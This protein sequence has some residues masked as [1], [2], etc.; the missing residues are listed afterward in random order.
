MPFSRN[1]ST[2]KGMD[3]KPSF[4]PVVGIR[5]RQAN[6][7]LFWRA[8]WV[9]LRKAGLTLPQSNGIGDR[10]SEQ[11]NTYQMPWGLAGLVFQGSRKLGAACPGKDDASLDCT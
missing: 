7:Q 4:D 3:W 8:M 10:K 11:V 1:G 2:N 6:V 5:H 9:E